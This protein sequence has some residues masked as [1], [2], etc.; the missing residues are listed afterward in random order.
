MCSPQTPY[1]NNNKKDKAEA[2]LKLFSDPLWLLS[3]AIMMN[4]GLIHIHW[5]LPY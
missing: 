2:T 5:Q 1:P 4:L 3:Y